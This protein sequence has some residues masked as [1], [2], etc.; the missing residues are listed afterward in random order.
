L[1]AAARQTDAYRQALRAHLALA[2]RLRFLAPLKIGGYRS[3]ETI[4]GEQIADYIGE[5]FSTMFKEQRID[6][7]ATTAFRRIA[8]TDIP[9]RIFP[10]FINLVN[11]AIYWTSQSGERRIRLDFKDGLAIVADSGPGVDPEDVPRLFN[12]FFTRRRSGRGV[13]LYLS[14]ANLSVAGHKIRYPNLHSPPS[15]N[16]QG[17]ANSVI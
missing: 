10:V 11:N 5:F 8:I 13:G 15:W 17:A 1:P 9:S 6:F 2:D 3:R 14:R 4:S 12:I 16:S 7:L